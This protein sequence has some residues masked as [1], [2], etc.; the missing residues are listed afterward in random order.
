M[1]E[2]NSPTCLP[3]PLP[4]SAS[5]S[6]N[7]S[8]A[9]SNLREEHVRR[10][11]P[12]TSEAPENRQP[13]APNQHSFLRCFEGEAVILATFSKECLT[14]HSSSPAFPLHA[15]YLQLAPNREPCVGAWKWDRTWYLAGSLAQQRLWHS[16]KLL[17]YYRTGDKQESSPA[18]CPYFFS[19]SRTTW[20]NST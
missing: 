5:K 4:D 6:V 13:R 17:A 20:Q 19:V 15:T 3:D 16:A 18:Q 7:G 9:F 1:L 8:A 14:E 11:G 12:A 10:F 2:N